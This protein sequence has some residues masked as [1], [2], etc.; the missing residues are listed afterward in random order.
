M[1]NENENQLTETKIYYNEIE[2]IQIKS[3]VYLVSL[4]MDANIGI[5][6]MNFHQ[7][8][9]FVETIRTFRSPTFMCLE[10][11]VYYIHREWH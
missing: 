6:F 2:I 5:N 10:Y 8:N 4:V 7:N 3:Y 1:E 11:K 9:K